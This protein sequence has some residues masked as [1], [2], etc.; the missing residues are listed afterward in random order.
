MRGSGS[1]WRNSGL[2]LM[3]R[4]GA[5]AGPAA[6]YSLAA[7]I[8]V[9]ALHASPQ[10]ANAQSD[11]PKIASCSHYDQ[12]PKCTE[13]E[14]DARRK[15]FGLQT[16]DTIHRRHGRSSAKSELVVG[17]ALIK[18][19]GGLALVFQR[20]LEGKPAVE[21]HR[22]LRNGQSRDRQP[23]RAKIPEEAWDAI[24]ANGDALQLVYAADEVLVC[25]ASFTIELVDGAGNVRAPVGDGCGN[26][27]RSV[28]FDFL[29]ETAIAQLPH[30][31]ALV[32]SRSDR[33]LDRLEQC[34]VLQGDKM[35]AAELHNIL[36]SPDGWPFWESNGRADASEIQ[37]LLDRNI[38]FSW[39]GIVLI[40]DAETAAQFWSGGWLFQYK[41]RHDVVYAESS[42]RVRV[43]GHVMRE[44][45]EDDGWTRK[46]AGTFISIWQRGDDGKFRMLHFEYSPIPARS[47]K[48]PRK[49]IPNR[50]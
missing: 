37:P 10:R 32:P 44:L 15:R 24:I 30:C 34:F 28:Y 43:G 23:L 14:R 11:P 49:A 6:A 46:Q 40:D 4:L 18:R 42:D 36:D 31:A 12:H 45:P 5:Q 22:I 33:N 13:D 19:S 35:V 16:L 39:P 21:I 41:F 29:A 27:P 7:I 47:P 2:F 26:E 9:L 8:T 50:Q 48:L 38:E 3:K 25:G 17:T 20:D 1:V